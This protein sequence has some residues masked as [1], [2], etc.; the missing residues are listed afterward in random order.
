MYY[1]VIVPL[2]PLELSAIHIV[3][4][5]DLNETAVGRAGKDRQMSALFFPFSSCGELRATLT[6][7]SACLKDRKYKKTWKIQRNSDNLIINSDSQ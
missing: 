1:N 5:D 4:Q 6:A 2:K 7:D 3:W